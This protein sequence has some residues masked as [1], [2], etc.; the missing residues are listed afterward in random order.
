MSLDDTTP[1]TDETPDK[2]PTDCYCSDL[3]DDLPG[4]LCEPCAEADFDQSPADDAVSADHERP[5]RCYCSDLDDRDRNRVCRFCYTACFRARPSD[6][7]DGTDD[8]PEMKTIGIEER[9]FVSLSTDV[10]VG[11]LSPPRRNELLSKA[12]KIERDFADAVDIDPQDY[13]VVEEPV[14]KRKRVYV[15]TTAYVGDRSVD[16]KRE[17]VEEARKAERRLLAE[18]RR[19]KTIDG[20]EP[21]A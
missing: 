16:E 6:D 13:P 20:I 4:E 5:R 8:T 18:A 10:Y 9:Q 11:D 1:T 15:E 17:M 7:V 21:V 12:R 2:R 14:P 3:D 19:I